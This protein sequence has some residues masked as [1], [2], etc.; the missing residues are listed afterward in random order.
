MKAEKSLG[1][2][3][4]DSLPHPA[5]LVGF[6]QIILFANHIAKDAGARVGTYC[7]QSFGRSQ[8]LS[9]E[10]RRCLNEH[11]QKVPPGGTACTF[12]LLNE[13]RAE[14]AL[15]CASEI[16]AFG[17]FWDTYWLPVT[18][19]MCLH[20]AIDVTERRQMQAATTESEHKYRALFQQ[21]ADPIVIIDISTGKVVEFNKKA[22]ENLGYTREEFDRLSIADFEVVESG[23]EILARL[24]TIRES[25]TDN[26]ETRHRTKSGALRDI[27]VSARAISIQ[28]RLFSQSVWHDITEQKNAEKELEKRVEGRTRELMATNARLR[29]EARKCFAAEKA[30]LQKE[31]LLAMEA[32]R[33]KEANSALRLMLR[34]HET[35]KKELQ[36]SVC[37]NILHLINPTLERLR[38]VATGTRQQELLIQIESLLNDI[39]FP[40]TRQI[41]SPL[42]GLTPSEVRVASL[43]REGRRT[44]EISAEL[45]L[46]ENTISSY[47]HKIRR[48]LRLLGKKVNLQSYLKSL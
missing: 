19:S 43:I 26:Y 7:W 20:Y 21:A 18:D 23:E 4:I 33:L 46:S 34:Q 48:K 8:F 36:E 38:Q 6:D 1:E 31:A 14:K 16:E 44:K 29:Y 25:G 28:G 45:H 37:S 41:S 10:H 42:I 27:A 17:R 39:V 30:L 3:I 15:K 9:S 47:R 24:Q 13:A 2:I 32:N 5:M 22:H 11:A 12:C 35:D 40:F